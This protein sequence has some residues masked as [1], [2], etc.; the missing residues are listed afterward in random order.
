MD[1]AKRS[2]RVTMRTSPALRKSRTVRSSV[3][4]FVVVPLLFSALTTVQPA[5]LSAATWIFVSWS[6]VDALA[7]P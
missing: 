4:P 2:I 1:R 6:S 5:A 7:Y 3:R